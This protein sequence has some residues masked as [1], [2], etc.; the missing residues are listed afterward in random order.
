M[1]GAPGIAAHVFDVVARS[2]ASIVLISQASS[3]C[4][5]CFCIAEKE[6]N[7][8]LKALHEALALELNAN[9][10]EN[11]TVLH[12]QAIVCVVGEN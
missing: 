12:D 6:A 7:H 1:K 10:I 5:I 8:V 3:E 11:I 2:G 9:I 4:S